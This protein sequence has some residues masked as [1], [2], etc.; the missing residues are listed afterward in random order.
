VPEHDRLIVNI[1]CDLYSSAFTVLKVLGAE[2][3]SSDLIYFHEF[4][5]N[6]H[7]FRALVEWLKTT[8]IEVHS[9]ALA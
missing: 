5:D 1:D 3:R 6:N 9:V 8:D 4:G 2:L 7:K